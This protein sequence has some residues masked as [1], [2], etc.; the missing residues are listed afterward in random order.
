[1]ASVVDHSIRDGIYVAHVLYTYEQFLKFVAED[2]IIPDP[3]VQREEV[4]N[5]PGNPQ[6]LMESLADN[7][8]IGGATGYVN[9]PRAPTDQGRTLT[10]SEFIKNFI[11]TKTAPLLL[12]DF[13][14]RRRWSAK[15]DKGQVKI[16][17]YTLPQLRENDRETYDVIMGA[18]IPV[19]LVFH[20]SGMVPH[21]YIA[22][23]FRSLQLSATAVVGER[24][25]ASDDEGLV[26]A[27]EAL[28]NAIS[29]PEIGR[30]VPES[31]G[32]GRAISHSL[33]I[34]ARYP[35]RMTLKTKDLERAT[36]M[37][38][39]DLAGSSAVIKRYITA[40][41]NVKTELKGRADQS[42]RHF[43]EAEELVK[44]AA[45]GEAKTAARAVADELKK[46]KNVAAA[47]H[48]HLKKCPLDL[49]LD[50]V[51]VHGCSTEPEVAASYI[52]RFFRAA[53]KDDASWD[54]MMKAVMA[55]T[56]AARSFNADVW[57]ARWTMLKTLIGEVRT[58]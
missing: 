20:S 21:P 42:E 38:D 22:R 50:G 48:N 9:G 56:T 10:N 39:A 31:R 47:S 32:Q 3:R 24:A 15:I 18:E 14:H 17:E 41:T 29:G 37:S 30:K 13:G 57:T 25:K 12:T 4:K 33:V 51:L 1:M 6:K 28:V 27:G 46:I 8:P 34:G 40:L 58:E 23:M 45:K 54:L 26:N 16:G 11:P 44:A 52:E 53:S 5:H 43:K 36:V 19:A 35:D 49:A 55:H 2:A 7:F